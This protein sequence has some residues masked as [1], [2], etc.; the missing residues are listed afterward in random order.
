[1][2]TLRPLRGGC[3]CGR[4]RYIIAVPQDGINEAQ[5]LFNTDSAHRKFKVTFK[6]F[7]ET[8]P[9]RRAYQLTTA[10][11]DIPCDTTGCLHPSSLVVVPQHHLL[12]LS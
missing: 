7:K 12:F 5:V 10:C 4:N 6:R 3:Q 9:E 11:R 8:L 1:M 2:N